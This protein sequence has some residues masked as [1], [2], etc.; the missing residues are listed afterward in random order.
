M[1]VF[2]SRIAPATA[3]WPSSR[4]AAYTILVLTVASMFSYIDRIILSLMITPIQ[5]TFD[6][7]D[8]QVGLLQGVAFGLFY[9]LAALPIGRLV[10]F[11]DRR[12]IIAVGAA[13]F[14]SFT[15]MSGLSRSYA[16]LFL[17]RVGVGAGEATLMPASYSILAD[18]YPKDKLAGALGVFTMG[19]FVG[20]GM[21]FVFGG[22]IVH[23]ALTTGPIDLPFIGAV[24]PWQT[25][26]LIVGAPGLLVAVW[27]ATL[28]EPLR[29]GVAAEQDGRLR[30]PPLSLVG[31]HVWTNR[32]LYLPMCAGYCM[33][34]LNSY[35]GTSWTAEF[36][37]RTYDWNTAQI[38]LWYGLIGVM[39]ASVLGAFVGGRVA[40]WIGKRHADA[41]LRVASLAMLCS[42]IPS[43]C[44][45][46]MPT[47]WLAL[48][49][50]AIAQFFT[51]FPFPLAAAAIQLATPNQLRGQMSALY[52]FTINLCGLGL[53]PVLVGLMNDAVF[54]T[55]EG[56][57]YSLALVN[58]L[59][60]PAAAL[61][62]WLALKP[63][64]ASRARHE[65][66]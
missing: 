32:A 25:A 46:L 12:L 38:G 45:T 53:G 5:A 11:W 50:L 31:A 6:I 1:A 41:P 20:I 16:E 49:V 10:D 43:A 28:R 66:A 37:R 17:A 51:T 64:R 21:A 40:D 39:T 18:T 3:P 58:A 23:W 52:L 36:F 65:E 22:A 30:A 33:I 61:L 54:P 63:Y 2:H 29:R 44:A 62:L 55:P 24:A 4:A 42:W 60:A 48:G 9:T 15:I 14:S 56:V 13:V 57:R 35:A 47:P 27:T 8:T 34:T 19:A 59:T 7:S 26:F